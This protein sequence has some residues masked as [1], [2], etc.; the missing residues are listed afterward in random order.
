MFKFC[1]QGCRRHAAGLPRH[2][3]ARVMQCLLRIEA[4]TPLIQHSNRSSIPFH[5][6]RS[7]CRLLVGY[8]AECA[9]LHSGTAALCTDIS[10]LDARPPHMHVAKLCMPIHPSALFPT[11]LTN[12]YLLYGI[13]RWCCA[14]R[15]LIL[16]FIR[17]WQRE[18]LQDLQGSHAVMFGFECW[19]RPSQWLAP[20]LPLDAPAGARPSGGGGEGAANGS[21]WQPHPSAA[22]GPAGR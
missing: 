7:Q 20:R 21:L 5:P 2:R 12:L 1:L 14:A 19:C 4:P 18:E 13:G 9:L 3:H 22:A 8:Q 11:S 6:I 16:H 15:D 10:L 17:G